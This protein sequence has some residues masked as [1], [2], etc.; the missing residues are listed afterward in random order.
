MAIG[1]EE[2]LGSV[3]D[4]QIEM[5]KGGKTTIVIV[6]VKCLKALPEIGGLSGVEHEVF[7]NAHYAK[8]DD[9][10]DAA[11]V[12]PPKKNE[13]FNPF[14]A[15][16]VGFRWF[17]G[18]TLFTKEVMKT[19]DKGV[20]L[21]VFKVLSSTDGFKIMLMTS[22]HCMLR[23]SPHCMLMTSPHCMHRCS[24]R[25]TDSRSWSTSTTASRS[26]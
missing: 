23:T 11:K 5:T 24:P 7:E 18:V 8:F 10:Y 12:A 6:C 19:P 13:E 16:P 20:Y 17:K 2:T 21:G 22:P 9:K 1:Q 4:L 14:A 26:R 15:N 3:Y 25:P